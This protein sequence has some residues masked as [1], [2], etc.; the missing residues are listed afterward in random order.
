MRVL[1]A[2]ALQ[3]DREYFKNLLFIPA[4]GAVQLHKELATARQDEDVRQNMTAA[5]SIVDAEVARAVVPKAAHVDEGPP[6]LTSA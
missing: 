2:S 6:A 1:V 5:K 4:Q 3:D